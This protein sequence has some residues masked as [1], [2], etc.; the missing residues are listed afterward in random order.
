MTRSYAGPEDLAAKLQEAAGERRFRPV[1]SEMIRH[2]TAYLQERDIPVVR[3]QTA[4]GIVSSIDNAFSANNVTYWSRG[5]ERKELVNATT[6]L[7]PKNPEPSGILATIHT[8]TPLPETVADEL[9][10]AYVQRWDALNLLLGAHEDRAHDDLTG[11]VSKYGLTN[12]IEHAISGQARNVTLLYI[13]LNDFKRINDTYGHEAGDRQIRHAASVFT[14]AV[15][16]ASPEGDLL[17]AR[18]HGDEFVIAGIDVNTE[19]VFRTVQYANNLLREPSYGEPRTGER[20]G[21]RYRFEPVPD[22]SF[23]FGY[24]TTTIATSDDVVHAIRQGL[25][26]ADGEMR[27]H[28][29]VTKTLRSNGD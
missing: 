14:K 25:D 11:L 8:A 7:E 1:L 29:R 13:D 3:E 16:R 15:R 9:R 22:L 5:A 19:T 26:E 24:T 23:S 21:E 4:L 10:A 2:T 27:G 17:A 18:L 28:K 12:A 20:S 6:L